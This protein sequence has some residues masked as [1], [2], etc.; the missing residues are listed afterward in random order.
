MQ[1]KL[2]FNQPAD[3][4]AMILQCAADST[5]NGK[6]VFV[7]GGK[8]YDT[9]EGYDKMQG[10]WMGEQLAVEWNCGQR[11]LGLVSAFHFHFPICTLSYV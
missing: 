7:A 10:Q 6:S 4:A 11:V 8:G 5:L 1:D 9:E 2:P 3:V